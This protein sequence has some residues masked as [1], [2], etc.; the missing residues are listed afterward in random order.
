MKKLLLIFFLAFWFT[1][2][3]AQVTTTTPNLGLVKPC[4]GGDPGCNPQGHPNW[5]PIVNSDYDI[6]DARIPIPTP[7]RVTVATLPAAPIA[8]Q[9]VVVT[10][11][12]SA[13][14][15]TVAGGTT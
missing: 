1:E 4:V 10:N 6:L 5:G 7:A 3:Q 14:S 8:N 13:G 15:C 9:V 11:A 12:L 2:A